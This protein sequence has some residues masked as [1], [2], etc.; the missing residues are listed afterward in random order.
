MEVMSDS[1][2]T[3][4]DWRTAKAVGEQVAGKGIPL[5]PVEQRALIEDFEDVVPQAERLVQQFARLNPGP[6]AT[7][8]WVMSR[9]QWVQANLRG[10]ERILEPFAEKFRIPN[11]DGLAGGIRRRV[12]AAQIGGLLGY[13]GHRVL[14]QYD[15]FLSPDDDGL[16]YFV[17]P[18][19]AGVEKQYR[20][21]TRDF[22][23]WLSLHEVTHRFQFGAATWLRGYLLGLVD[24]YL[25]SIELD[26]GWLVQALRRALGEILSGQT[27]HR[28][29]GWVFLL[30]TREQRE[31]VR[32][33]QA[34]MSLLE[35]HGNHVMDSVAADRIPGAG[36]FRRTLKERRH[37]GG[38]EGAF[39]KAIGFDVKVR[40]YDVGERFV[41]EAIQRAGMDAFNRV[42][43]RPENLPSMDE[44]GR[45]Q[46]WVVRVASG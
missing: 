13:L 16:I 8:G 10:F 33:M 1:S 44:I 38:P 35:G 22:R 32:Q 18:N 5:S 12:L 14:G 3:L 39:Q 31:L 21:E 19:I 6:P 43:E 40:Q 28:G 2:R 4:I 26:P 15:V 25:D 17:G 20:F 45:P 34:L 11:P 36:S 9:G 23:L 30:M 7:K 29:F 46:D 37:R 41:A 27:E 42:W 24:T